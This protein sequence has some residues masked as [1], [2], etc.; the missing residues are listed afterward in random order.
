MPL[1]HVC[2]SFATFPYIV[3]YTTLHWRRGKQANRFVLAGMALLSNLGPFD[4]SAEHWPEYCERVELHLAANG[5]DDAERKR[6]ALLSVC[7]AS[8]Y[9]L[10]RSLVTPDKPTDKTFAEIVKLVKDHLTPQSSFVYDQR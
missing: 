1:C 5:I 6:A 9:H 4:Q 3:V 10:I 8:T 7:G 2:F